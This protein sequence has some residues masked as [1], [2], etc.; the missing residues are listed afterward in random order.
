MPKSITREDVNLEVE[1]LMTNPFISKTNVLLTLIVT[2]ETDINQRFNVNAD[3]TI[4]G[5]TGAQNIHC[6]SLYPSDEF[7]LPCHDYHNNPTVPIEGFMYSN[8]ALRK[9]VV[10]EKNG[11]TVIITWQ[12]L[13]WT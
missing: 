1:S 8:T 6:T 5:V 2:A 4:K 7:V 3:I 12:Q 13:N 10:C 11:Q 9:V